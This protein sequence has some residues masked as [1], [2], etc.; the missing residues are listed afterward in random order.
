MCWA[1]DCVYQCLSAVW[2]QLIFWEK[3]S[4]WDRLL[5]VGASLGKPPPIH[6]CFPQHYTS[7]SR[8]LQRSKNVYN[9]N[10]NTSTL[11]EITFLICI[12]I[13]LN[14]WSYFQRQ[15]LP[16]GGGYY[17]QFCCFADKDDESECESVTLHNSKSTSREVQKLWCMGLV[18][19]WHVE[20]SQTRD[21]TCVPC[22]GRWILIHCT[23][24]E[25]QIVSFF[26]SF[27]W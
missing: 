17:F 6:W 25:V 5:D 26:S 13:V 23:T 14:G 9:L 16:L 22:I 4:H 18:A 1:G 3:D 20:S 15:A 10:Q 11:M 27:L 7:C 8:K 19:P 12:C 21:W 2:G 24:R